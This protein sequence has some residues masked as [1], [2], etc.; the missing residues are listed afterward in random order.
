MVRRLLAA[1]L[2]PPALAAFAAQPR[3]TPPGEPAGR[4]L[5][6]DALENELK[7]AEY[8]RDPAAIVGALLELA[9]INRE[10]GRV[11]IAL[12]YSRRALAAAQASG[13]RELVDRSWE[14]V[15]AGQERA[16]DTPGALASYRRYKDEHDRLIAEE[17]HER[18]AR[19]EQ[20]YLAERK[21]SEA[22]RA[23]REAA[24]QSIAADRRRL[25]RSLFGGSTILLALIGFTIYRRRAQRTR[26]TRELAVTDPLTGLKNRRY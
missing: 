16:G 6:L 13:S 3:S 26:T 1:L 25:A 7:A 19:A 2:L 21:A 22:E 11:R 23:H 5:A 10:Q 17:E 14:D 24:Q 20:K 4:A 12:D 8:S 18:L 15:I 9:R